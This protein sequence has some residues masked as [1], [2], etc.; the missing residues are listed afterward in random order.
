M[1]IG[2][3]FAWAHLQ[4][5]GG[6]A[7]FAMFRLFPELIEFADDREDPAKHS[8]F[9]AREDLVAGKLRMCNVRRLPAYL[10]SWA[11]WRARPGNQVGRTSM[12]SPHEI[13]EYPRAD[14]MLAK[15][16]DDNRFPV[17]RW[18]RMEYLGEDFLAF[19]SD[20]AEVGE[21]R[22]K[23]V[24]ETRAI[25]ALDYDHEVRHWFSDAQIKRM[26]ELNPIWCEIEERAYG[27]LL[28]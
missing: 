8:S 2:E 16:T 14:R 3:K 26:Y 22:S 12:E 9:G 18:L 21:D 23:Q 13:S 27:D 19:A 1:V 6:S 17:E 7:T 20:L 4:K 11:V 24:R 15:I 10:L 25:N 28:A 5:T